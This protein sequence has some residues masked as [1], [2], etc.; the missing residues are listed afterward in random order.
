LASLI[1]VCFISRIFIVTSFG[2][3]YLTDVHEVP[4]AAAGKMLGA[5]L[6]G[7]VLGTLFFGWVA[8]RTGHRKYLVVSLSFLAAICGAIYAL[9][10]VG[11]SAAALVA[12]LFFFTFFSGGVIPLMLVIIPT[13][14]VPPAQ[15]ASAIGIANFAGEFFGAGLFP[16]LGGIVGDLLG[17]RYTMLLGAIVV[18]LAALLGLALIDRRGPS[19]RLE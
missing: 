7:D 5:S 11:T 1:A 14:S 8:D 17:L 6:A 19:I 2:A 4:L 13:E 10:P 18:G 12:T 15:A 3:L 16:I 9:A